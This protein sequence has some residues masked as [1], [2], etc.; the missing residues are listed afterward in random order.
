MKKELLDKTVVRVA[1]GWVRD[2]LLG[3]KSDDIDLVINNLT[4]VAFAEYVNKYLKHVHEETHR[5]GVIVANPELSKHLETAKLKVL[6]HEV[7][8]VNLRKES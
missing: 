1:G 8:F 4:G 6:S 5:I 7:D 2:K 3:R